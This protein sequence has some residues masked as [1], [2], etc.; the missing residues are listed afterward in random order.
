MMSKK[1]TALFLAV[2]MLISLTACGGGASDNNTPVGSDQAP[3]YAADFVFKAKD[4]VELGT[5]GTFLD[6]Q[7][8]Y[9]NLTYVPEMFYGDYSIIGKDAEKQYGEEAN[10]FKTTL[11]G[12]EAELT[13]LPYRLVAGPHNMAHRVNSIEG[14]H[15]MTAYFMH[16]YENGTYLDYVN[17]AYTIDG[18]KL[19]LTPLKEFH[20]D[21]ET[22]TITYAFDDVSWTYEFE[23]SGRNLTLR[24]GSDSIELTSGLSAYKEYD[25]FH[26][27]SYLSSGSKPANGIDNL[28]FRFNGEDNG[29]NFYVE[30]TDGTD[31]YNAVAGITND[32]LFIITIPY[33]TGTK[34]YQ[35]VYFYAAEDG[36]ILTDGT[37]IYYYNDDYSDRNRN[38][39][40]QYV[41]IDQAEKLEEM[42]ETK[43][44]QLVEKKENLLEDLTAAFEEAG[45]SVSVDMKTGEMA[46]DSAILFGGESAELT[47]DGKAFLNTFMNVYTTVVFSEKYDGFVEKTMVEGHTAPI[48]GSTY[49]SGLPLSQERAENVKAYCL[50]AETGVDVS[51]LASAM[52][53]I[54]YSNSKPITD[55]NGE[56]NIEA[57]RRVCFRFVIDL[58]QL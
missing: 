20:V 48:E 25:F 43:L 46:L 39:L 33:E 37:D 54:G 57:S 49:E 50:S 22:N 45:I 5:P 52:E 53:S 44:E 32:G 17:C 21:D 18:N 4:S 24:S 56:V 55:N 13:T 16:R 40:N 2:M 12:K 42:T 31:Y 27:S 26:I 38:D 28:S 47:A 29:S 51:K 7:T 35:Y 14:Y 58:D 19:T 11:K 41:S 9:D 3:A 23:F 6:P 1:M 10:Y 8:I 36:M 30:T 34:T 15:W